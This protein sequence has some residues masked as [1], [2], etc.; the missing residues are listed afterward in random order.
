M[1]RAPS[2][3]NLYQPAVRI[4]SCEHFVAGQNSEQPLAVASGPGQLHCQ[5][6][7]NQEQV[8]VPVKD[9]LICQCRT[10]Q[11]AEL[12]IDHIRSQPRAMNGDQPG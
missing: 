2:G 3:A 5:V 1:I 8:A 10:A 9:N 7:A 11:G 6:T 12:D 4:K